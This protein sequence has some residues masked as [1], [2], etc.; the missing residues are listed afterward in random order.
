[1][2]TTS[3]RILYDI[4]VEQVYNTDIQE[5]SQRADRDI[6]W[7]MDFKW[8]VVNKVFLENYAIEFFETIKKAWYTSIQIG[9][10]ES[11]AIPIVWALVLL[12]TE[13]IICNSFYIRKSRKKS[14]LP[15]LIEWKVLQDIPI[16]LVDDLINTGTSFKK[17]EVILWEK[18]SM[19]I[20]GVFVALRFR[21]ADFYTDFHSK[22]IT[23]WSIFEL[24]D[25]ADTLGIQNIVPS[26]IDV[27]PWE[28]Y[29]IYSR[30]ELCKA[31]PYLVIP[32]SAPILDQ[33]KLYM[34]IDDWR[35]LCIDTLT[36]T[37]LWSFKILFGSKGKRI[38]SSPA[39]YR[40]Y[41]FF[42]AY[43]GTFYCLDKNNG[44]IIWTFMDADWIGSSP[45]INHKKWIVYVW[46]E[47]GLFRKRGGVVAIEIKTGKT[48]WRD[49]NSMT[50]YTHASPAYNQKHTI[51]VCW[52]ND[53]SMH[54]FDA[55]SGKVKWSY[56][57]N[58][59]IKYSAIFDDTRNVVIF[60]SMDGGL[61][62]LHAS[63]GTLYHRFEARFGFYSNPIQDWAIIYIG[64]LDKVVYAYHLDTKTIE[65]Q[66]ET[67]GRIYASP[68]I[69][70][71]RLFIG[72]NDGRL[73]E[74]DIATGKVNA[75]IQLSERIV[76]RVQ[77]ETDEYG[78]RMIYILTHAC[79]LYKAIEI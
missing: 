47:F 37:I 34:G 78:K 62:V 25:F 53:G 21:D 16:I 42:G 66:Y 52:S 9:G 57:T 10:L 31:N 12:D 18:Y 26:N 54:C 19:Q 70:D 15:N 61:Y 35:F 75:T 4:I 46:L 48:L 1:M 44:N 43:D 56:K 77:I 23:I 50:E 60:G 69:D 22:N 68:I 5:I 59:E 40:E 13:N 20:S 32:K 11:T 64:S 67:S 39:I 7:V 2:W 6:T 51:V 63:D 28:K 73:Y 79:E 58:G 45:C 30:T 33:K 72:S 8:Q 3:R 41:V 17:Q 38:L 24:N 49:Y 14:S 65:W 71:D 36:G 76:N 27:P 29:K 55:L 74:F